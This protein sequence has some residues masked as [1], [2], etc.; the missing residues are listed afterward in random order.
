LWRK[1]FVATCGHHL[2]HFTSM[3]III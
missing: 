3:S 1:N 2:N